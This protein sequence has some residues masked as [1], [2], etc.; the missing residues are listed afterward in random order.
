MTPRVLPFVPQT[1]YFQ[2]LMRYARCFPCRIEVFI[3]FSLCRLH[4]QKKFSVNVN[5]LLKLKLIKIQTLTVKTMNLKMFLK[6]IFH[7]SFSEH[8][9]ESEEDGYSGNE[10]VNNLEWFS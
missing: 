3:G 7:E 10:E 2:R 6:L 1:S 9:T 5:F 8:D 4:T